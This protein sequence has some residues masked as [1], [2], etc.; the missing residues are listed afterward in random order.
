M[1][2]V[3]GLGNPGEKYQNTPHNIGFE[4]IECFARKNNFPD[5]V[6]SKKTHSLASKKNSIILIKPQN[7]MNNSGKAA[8]EAVSFWKEKYI[9]VVHDDID[10]PF[11]KIK[12]AENRGSAGHKGVES[13][14]QETGKKQL[15]RIRIGVKPEKEVNNPER[16]VVKKFHQQE[17]EIKDVIKRA[18][19]ALEDILEKGAEKAMTKYN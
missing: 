10:L 8:K 13:I 1:A 11:G 12:I 17:Q 2:L 9:I 16:F 15:T 4:I 14:I 19:N 7:F 6:F 18:V 3:I 5:F